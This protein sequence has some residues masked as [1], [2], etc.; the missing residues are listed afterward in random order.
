MTLVEAVRLE[1]DRR[2]DLLGGEF[3]GQLESVK[4]LCLAN[5]DESS[6]VIADKVEAE[7]PEYFHRERV[8]R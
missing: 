8:C 7:M 4:R 2:W 6:L 3:P 5:S 1:L